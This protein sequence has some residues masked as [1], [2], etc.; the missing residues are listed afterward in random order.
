M[1]KKN[2]CCPEYIAPRYK[3]KAVQLTITVGLACRR[4]REE[5]THASHLHFNT[6]RFIFGCKPNRNENR[7]SLEHIWKEKY[8]LLESSAAS[9]MSC[10]QKK[11]FIQG[12]SPPVLHV[13]LPF[14]HSIRLSKVVTSLSFMELRMKYKY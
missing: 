4:I 13:S 5:H 12:K 9:I 10:R 1:I 2:V 11:K 14:I 7:H 3:E 8:G 6:I